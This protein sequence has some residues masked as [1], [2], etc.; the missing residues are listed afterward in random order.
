MLASME[1]SRRSSFEPAAAGALL[2]GVTAAGIGLGVLI[3]W[4][5]GSTGLGAVG[6]AVV[7]IPAGVF[8]VY[9]RYRSFF[10]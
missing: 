2:G 5:A 7:G 6:G 8:V 9:R 4:A 3:G 1:A 10:T